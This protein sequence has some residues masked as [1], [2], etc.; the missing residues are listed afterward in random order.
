MTTRREKTIAGILIFFA[1]ITLVLGFFQMKKTLHAPLLFDAPKKVAV[2]AERNEIFSVDPQKDTD[3][4]GLRDSDE[5]SRYGTSAYLADSD[6]DGIPDGIEIKNGTDP[7]CPEG[8]QCGVMGRNA[9]QNAPRQA[10]M[11]T[12]ILDQDATMT[13]KGETL[14]PSTE[15]GSAAQLRAALKA[16]GVP[17]TQL[18]QIDDATLLDMYRQTEE[19]AK[20]KT[21]VPPQTTTPQKL[22]GPEIRALL[23]AQGMAEEELAQITDA[24]LESLFLEGMKQKFQKTEPATTP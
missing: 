1:G 14:Q 12:D 4:D 17:Q 20:K 2:N 9:L 24:D 3:G 22:T 13:Q 23:K 11:L 8:K 6:S 19:D 15:V 7:N 5:L 10:R 18:D 21:A 16:A